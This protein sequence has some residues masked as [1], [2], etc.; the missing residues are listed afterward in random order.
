MLQ[1]QRRHNSHRVGFNIGN[2]RHYTIIQ[3]E[4][5]STEDIIMAKLLKNLLRTDSSAIFS[6]LHHFLTLKIILLS[7]SINGR[8]VG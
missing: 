2:L 5:K 8:N 3:Q 6:R 1:R 7:V 4:T